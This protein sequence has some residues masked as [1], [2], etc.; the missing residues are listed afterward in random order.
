[1]VQI[2]EKYSDEIEEIWKNPKFQEITVWNNADKVHDRIISRGYAIHK[3]V[4]KNSILFIGINP[5]FKKGSDTKSHF[6]SMD[7]TENNLEGKIH[8]YFKKFVDISNKLS[9]KWSHLDFFF[10]RETKQ[11]FVD[12]LLKDNISKDFLDKQ[13]QISREIILS[14]KPKII[15]V[16]NTAARY[17][18]KQN[19]HKISTNFEFE[20]NP[21]LGTEIIIN[22]SELE[23]TPVFFTSMLTGQRAI[24]N[25]SY[26][27][28]IWHLDFV[29]KQIDKENYQGL[30]YEMRNTDF[31]V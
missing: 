8:P 24:D 6:F 7:Q 30:N 2:E 21:E 19:K 14:A 28:L 13:L 3:E 16:S 20:F 26:N 5:S 4:I 10:F 15:V 23:G 22:N 29:L 27:R 17:F 25:G 9:I 12:E 1:M 18:M 31:L 11:R